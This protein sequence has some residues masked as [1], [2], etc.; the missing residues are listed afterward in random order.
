MLYFDVVY[1]IAKIQYNVVF[2]NKKRYYI[3]VL[4]FINDIEMPLF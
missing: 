2:T 3:A 1:Y 4:H